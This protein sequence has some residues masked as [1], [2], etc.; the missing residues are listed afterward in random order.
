MSELEELVRLKGQP[1]VFATEDIMPR[2][3]AAAF[4]VVVRPDGIWTHA[5]TVSGWAQRKFYRFFADCE[6]PSD[7]RMANPQ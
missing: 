1:E 7:F 4:Q 2:Y 3:N 5:R 6:T